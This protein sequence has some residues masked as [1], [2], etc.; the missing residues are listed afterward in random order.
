MLHNPGKN[1]LF[2]DRN[3]FSSHIP[4]IITTMTVYVND[5]TVYVKGMFL[6]VKTFS[7]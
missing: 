6:L 2:Y 4:V 5:V 7:S 3:N 1:S